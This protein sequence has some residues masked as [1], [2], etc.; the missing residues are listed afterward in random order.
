MSTGLSIWVM[1]LVVFNMG[2]TFFLYLW[3]PRAKIPQSPD[4]T[5]GHLWAGGAIREGL[6]RLPRWWLIS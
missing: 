5:T 1:C 2:V 3:G 6:H 4:G